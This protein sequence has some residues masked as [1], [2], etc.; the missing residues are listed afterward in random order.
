MRPIAYNHRYP[1]PSDPLL[2][3]RYRLLLSPWG[4]DACGVAV[5][6]RQGYLILSVAE[7]VLATPTLGKDPYG[8]ER[9]VDAGRDVA[10]WR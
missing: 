10:R 4:G 6:G 2:W 1:T 9:A 8:T 3:G 5:D 7:A